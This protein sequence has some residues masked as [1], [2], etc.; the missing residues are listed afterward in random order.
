[1]VSARVLLNQ[2]TGE[3]RRFGFVRFTDKVA[4]ATAI[5]ATDGVVVV[6]GG[7]SLRV[8][9]ASAPSSPTPA[10]SPPS[11]PTKSVRQWPAQT[12]DSSSHGSHSGG[13]PR[14]L[15]QPRALNA[16]HWNPGTKGM[17][18]APPSRLYTPSVSTS[19]SYSTH[20]GGAAAGAT[21]G[22]GEKWAVQVSGFDRHSIGDVWGV[23]SKFG[24]IGS[25]EILSA[26]D[27]PYTQPTSRAESAREVDRP[28]N[29][30][31]EIRSEV[32]AASD[33]K[34][35]MDRTG[36]FSMSGCRGS[37]GAVGDIYAPAPPTHEDTEDCVALVTYTTMQAALAAVLTRPQD[38][39]PGMQFL[40]IVPSQ[41]Q[42]QISNPTAMM[43]GAPTSMALPTIQT[44]LPPAPPCLGHLTQKGHTTRDHEG[45][46][47][48]MERSVDDLS[49]PTRTNSMFDL[50]VDYLRTR[51][52]PPHRTRT[53]PPT[54]ASF[55]VPSPPEKPSRPQAW[56]LEREDGEVD[57]HLLQTLP[58]WEDPDHPGHPGHLISGSGTPLKPILTPTA[59]GWGDEGQLRRENCS[60]L[61][62]TDQSK[63]GCM[64]GSQDLVAH[65]LQ[66]HLQHQQHQHQPFHKHAGSSWAV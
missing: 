7:D 36:S 17:M 51:T 14:G 16:E 55:V 61:H 20:G 47:A 58:Y 25:L 18:Q 11:S 2:E 53:P 24:R 27:V 30:T 46:H 50:G 57:V 10:P 21:A 29:A 43:T 5:K 54:K 52:P 15:L 49:G 42:N 12:G 41:S 64:S 38:L 44:V 6:H 28:W 34:L 31:D 23:L 48:L 8:V 32:A 9:E 63:R 19:A 13:D 45:F 35:Y 33:E 1:M 59:A 37:G 22:G 40:R 39:P 56:D 3:S 65:P 66:H 62:V 26:S 60:C 4:R